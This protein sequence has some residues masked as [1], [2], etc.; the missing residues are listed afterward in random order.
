[1]SSQKEILEHPKKMTFA[2]RKVEKQ[3]FRKFRGDI[4]EKERE[5]H[6][7]TDMDSHKNGVLV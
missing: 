6:G 2:A 7:Q 3:S 1:L 5:E 4:I